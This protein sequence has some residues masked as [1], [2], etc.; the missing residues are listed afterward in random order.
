VR[1]A[2]QGR[3]RFHGGDAELAPGLSLHKIGGHT[4]GLQAVRVHTRVGWIVL[5]SDASHLY[6]NMSEERPFPIVYD[7]GEMIEGYRRLR[8][9]ADAPELIVP[10]HDP[11]V[12]ERYAAATAELEGIVVRL[13]Q[14]PRAQRGP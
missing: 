11:L 8:E 5:A 7:V 12:M 2:Y 13:D 9:L 6:A 4:R 10:G 14:R 1:K 3:V